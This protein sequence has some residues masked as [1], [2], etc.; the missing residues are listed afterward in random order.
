MKDQ[1]KNK[2]RLIE[3][4]ERRVEERTA[5]V[6]EANQELQREID[7]RKRVQDGAGEISDATRG[8]ANGHSEASWAAARR[9]SW[10]CPNDRSL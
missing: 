1:D 4:L 7:Q 9:L 10:T 5:E 8:A 6:T 2:Q 3:E